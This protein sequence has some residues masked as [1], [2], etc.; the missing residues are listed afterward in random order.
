[1][2]LLIVL[3]GARQI[4]EAAVGE[5]RDLEMQP[6]RARG[7]GSRFT[8]QLLF[9]GLDQVLGVLDA[10][11]RGLVLVAR[12]GRL[13]QRG[14]SLAVTSFVPNPSVLITAARPA[15]L[16]SLTA[17]GT[18][19]CE[20]AAAAGVAVAFGFD[21]G[22]AFAFDEFDGFDG[23]DGGAGRRRRLGKYGRGLRVSTPPR[24]GR[25]AR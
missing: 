10:R 13:H 1:M 19:A 20:I 18:G 11:D 21:G 9:A 24:R 5:A 23:F 22:T 14:R 15:W 2:R 3:S 17:T 7:R 12:H 6:P 25:W 4:A 16:S 8:C